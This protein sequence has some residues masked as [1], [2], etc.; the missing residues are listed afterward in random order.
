[1]VCH[2]WI[3]SPCECRRMMHPKPL[4]VTRNSLTTYYTSLCDS[5]RRNTYSL[6]KGLLI[7]YWWL[8]KYWWCLTS[9]SWTPST[10]SPSTDHL[11]KFNVV[12]LRHKH[13]PETLFILNTVHILCPCIYM[14]CETIYFTC[15]IHFIHKNFI[16]ENFT[17]PKFCLILFDLILFHLI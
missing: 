13:S 2:H 5:S 1:M 6:N 12:S 14:Q 16:F 17:F 4:E 10:S 11:L 8:V 9:T 3:S 15:Q 7:K